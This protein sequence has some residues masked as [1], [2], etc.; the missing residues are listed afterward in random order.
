VDE[1]LGIFYFPAEIIGDINSCICFL[2]VVVC[3]KTGIVEGPA[4]CIVNEE[5][6]AVRIR[7]CYV[8]VVVGELGDVACRC[9]FPFEAFEATGLKVFV[10]VKRI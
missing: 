4:E 5:D 10:I 1:H 3:E 8:G 2:R 7:A 9:A 6:G